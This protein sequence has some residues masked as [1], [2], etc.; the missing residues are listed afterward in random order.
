MP[1]HAPCRR[2]AR[3]AVHHIAHARCRAP[4]LLCSSRL[5][6]LTR[7]APPCVTGFSSLFDDSMSHFELAEE[8]TADTSNVVFALFFVVFWPSPHLSYPGEQGATRISASQANQTAGFVS[9]VPPAPAR[10]SRSNPGQFQ[11]F[12]LTDP[13]HP[14]GPPYLLRCVGTLGRDGRRSRCAPPPP[15][16][17]VRWLCA[18]ESAGRPCGRMGA[19]GRPA[20]VP[21]LDSGG[22]EQRAQTAPSV[23]AH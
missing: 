11:D 17:W 18:L 21:C 1:S 23:A 3:L 10:S 16:V 19:V 15:Q 22:C 12:T 6:A 4:S 2:P 8:G 9:P 13:H 20:S 5:T 7:R 14:P